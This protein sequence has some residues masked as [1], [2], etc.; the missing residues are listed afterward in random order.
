[1]RNAQLLR[2]TFVLLVCWQSCLARD[3]HQ[4]PK[5]EQQQ[6]QA[7]NEPAAALAPEGIATA[8]PN[9]SSSSSNRTIAAGLNSTAG[10][11]RT[12]P[13]MPTPAAGVG[14][15]GE[16]PM[17]SQDANFCMQAINR[18]DVLTTATA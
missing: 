17:A 14:L 16:M 11:N 1:M 13:G 5:K 12:W 15:N 2:A 3:I 8:Q 18:N 9:N 10:G 6:Q 7:S 4:Q